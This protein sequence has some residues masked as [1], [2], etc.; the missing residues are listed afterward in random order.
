MRWIVPLLLLVIS[1]Q[2]A[3]ADNLAHMEVDKVLISFPQQVPS[4]EP[5][6]ISARYIGSDYKIVILIPPPGI[7]VENSLT[8]ISFSFDI[9]GTMDCRDPEFRWTLKLNSTA[10]TPYTFKILVISAPYSVSLVP[11]VRVVHGNITFG[12]ARMSELSFTITAYNITG[13][14]MQYFQQIST[15]QQQVSALQQENSKLRTDLYSAQAKVQNLT[16]RLE[17]MNRTML[18]MSSFIGFL[19][20]ENKTVETIGMFMGMGLITF[21][22]PYWGWKTRKRRE[23]ELLKGRRL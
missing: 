21:L 15:L 6:Q 17:D 19:Y 5:F 4:G 7:T 11:S 2:V 1:V 10:E 9:P 13:M 20:W 18:N 23:N 22:V 16:K 3:L 8:P 14:K 12:N